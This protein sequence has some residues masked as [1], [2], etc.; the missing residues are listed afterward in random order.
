MLGIPRLVE[1][2]SIN[3]SLA[4][5]DESNRIGSVETIVGSTV[6]KSGLKALAYREFGVYFYERPIGLGYRK[7]R[8]LFDALT[9]LG[10]PV[11][12]E[13]MASCA[14]GLAHYFKQYDGTNRVQALQQATNEMKLVGPDLC[15]IAIGAD[16]GASQLGRATL[17]TSVFGFLLLFHF[18]AF[19]ICLTLSIMARTEAWR[20]WYNDVLV[21]L[22]IL[23]SSVNIV[24]R[25]VVS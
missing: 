24:L 1:Q 22:A 5:T 25:S 8:L 9:I 17:L 21:F 16:F 19:T 6:D 3:Y 10:V 2:L 12:C 23:T 13:V 4:G 14:R 15:L 18:V 7:V 11:L 20:I